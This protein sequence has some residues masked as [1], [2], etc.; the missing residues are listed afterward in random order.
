[1]TAYRNDL[2]GL[3]AGGKDDQIAYYHRISD[4]GRNGRLH[5]E[6]SVEVEAASQPLPSAGAIA[7]D[8][9]GMPTPEEWRKLKAEWTH[10][11]S[12]RRMEERGVKYEDEGERQ[13][14]H[15]AARGKAE[16]Q[17]GKRLPSPSEIIADPRRFLSPEQLQDGQ[18]RGH[19]KGRE[20]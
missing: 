9:D 8:G 1:L 20:R 6:G 12:L 19:E 7:D 14:D 13:L 4:L 10:D 17:D 5:D 15:A 2:R 18:D 11:Y 3:L 16:G